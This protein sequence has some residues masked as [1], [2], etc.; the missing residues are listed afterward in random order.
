MLIHFTLMNLFSMIS[1]YQSEAEGRR[2]RIRDANFLVNT[3]T[4]LTR[5]AAGVSPSI[6]HIY[7]Y[8]I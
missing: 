5:E 1:L 8:N 2:R 4:G 3:E 7:K 6:Y